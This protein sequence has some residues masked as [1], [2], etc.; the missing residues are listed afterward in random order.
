MA[1]RGDNLEEFSAELVQEI[2]DRGKGYETQFAYALAKAVDKAT[3]DSVR[4]KQREN[5]V[6]IEIDNGD[7]A[8]GTPPGDVIDLK[9][10]FQ[11]STKRKETEDGGWYLVI[12]MRRYTGKSDRSFGMSSRLYKDL[13]SQRREGGYAQLESSYLYDNRRPGSMISELNYETKSKT[14]TRTPQKYRGH[15]YVSFRTVSDKSHPASWVINRSKA[16]PENKTKEVQR[17]IDEVTA[18]N[19]RLLSK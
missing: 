18:Y 12:P 19:K 8:K 5:K 2:R 16:D 11:Q 9:K 15:Q 6:D 13:L 1:K 17:I 7:E 14:I 4:V 10:F 3:D